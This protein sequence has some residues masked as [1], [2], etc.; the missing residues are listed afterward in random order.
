MPDQEFGVTFV[1]STYK[2]REDLLRCLQSIL[3]RYPNSEIVVVNDDP[4]DDLAIDY[5]SPFVYRRNQTNLGCPQSRNVGAN[6]VKT[7]YAFFLDDDAILGDINLEMAMKVMVENPSVVVC[8]FPARNH[9]DNK[10]NIT[11]LFSTPEMNSLDF[12]DAPAFNGGASL[13]K[14]DFFLPRGY[15][16]R[17]RGYGEEAELTLRALSSGFR[18]VT[19]QN[20]GAIDH[21]PSSDAREG[22]LANQRMNDIATAFEYGGLIL[23]F[24]QF[25]AH[26]FAAFRLYS[27]R[28]VGG[29]ARGFFIG[30]SVLN[31]KDKNKKNVYENW[32]RLARNQTI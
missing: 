32:L 9:I 24:R 26:T 7:D 2:R 28:Q 29:C 13:I 5:R 18:V 20:G 3:G 19:L 11:G 17:I 1:I 4:T 8:G 10:I 30:F 25:L 14:M 15:S 23:G 12:F 21:F 31:F 16:P 27:W 22:N 6:L